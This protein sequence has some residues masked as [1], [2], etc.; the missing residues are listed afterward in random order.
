MLL[1]D[2]LIIS[3]NVLSLELKISLFA[4]GGVN[5][6]HVFMIFNIFENLMLIVRLTGSNNRFKDPIPR[7][8]A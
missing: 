2:K 5:H 4:T 1:L 7:W 3:H 6:F 8:A